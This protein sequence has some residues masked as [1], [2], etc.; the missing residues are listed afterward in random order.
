MKV[1]LTMTE[2]LNACQLGAIRHFE[3]VWKG[4]KPRFQ[5]KEGASLL[6]HQRGALGELAFCKMVNR[7]WHPHYNLFSSP[8]FGVD[9]EIRTSSMD[10]LKVKEDDEGRVVSM[11]IDTECNPPCGKYNGWMNVS[12]AKDKRWLK[13]PAGYG[14]PAYFV[15]LEQL[16]KEMIR[17]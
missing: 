11:T 10:C 1:E 15:P 16:N 6:N 4:R 2:C 12:E 14:H 13:D 5:M 8:D 9:V 7:Y 3:S 17:L